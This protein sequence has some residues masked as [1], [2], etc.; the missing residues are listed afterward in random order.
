MSCLL[1]TS[2]LMTSSKVAGAAARQNVRLESTSTPAALVTTARESRAALVIVDL[3]T[4]GLD[5]N[6]LVGELL[7]LDP[8][9]TRV[10]AFGPHV[11]EAKLQAAL[12]AGCDTVF[13]RGQFLGQVDAILSR[14]ESR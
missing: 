1:L 8:A 7:A 3:T 10:I 13:A 2:D 4:R 6:T 5:I 9:P 14:A 12:D 11:H